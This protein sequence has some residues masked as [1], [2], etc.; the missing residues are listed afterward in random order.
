MV[1]NYRRIVG[2]VGTVLSLCCGA[3]CFVA[4]NSVLRVSGRV[5]PRAQQRTCSVDGALRMTAESEQSVLI[6]VGVTM[7]V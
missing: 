7:F 1:T 5:A 4:Q 6:H 2:T 3:Q